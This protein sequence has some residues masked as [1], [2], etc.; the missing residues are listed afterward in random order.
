M[1]KRM[2]KL[3]LQNS[4]ERAINDYKLVDVLIELKDICYIADRNN[5]GWGWD[6]DARAIDSILV[7]IR[8]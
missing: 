6:S 4:L 8:N 7:K 2:T 5:P 1:S 3:Q